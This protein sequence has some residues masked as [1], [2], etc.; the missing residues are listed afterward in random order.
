MTNL[1]EPLNAFLL[2]RLNFGE[3]D[4]DLSSTLYMSTDRRK[5]LDCN[6]LR[7]FERGGERMRKKGQRLQSNCSLGRGEDTTNVFRILWPPRIP[8]NWFNNN[9]DVYLVG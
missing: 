6:C 1:Y 5:D 4:E 8:S 9:D 3:I 2:V 7:F